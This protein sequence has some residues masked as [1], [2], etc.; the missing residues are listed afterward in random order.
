VVNGS[1]VPFLHTS[2]IPPQFPHRFR[3]CFVAR[4][5]YTRDMRKTHPL[6]D[7]PPPATP[8]RLPAILHSQ[9]PRIEAPGYQFESKIQ[10]IG[11]M[12]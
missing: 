5:A 8:A 4:G 2:H 1:V 12:A 11:V 7:L 9:C 3:P 6:Q 10:D